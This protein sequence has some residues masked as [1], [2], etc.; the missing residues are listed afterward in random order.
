M[1]IYIRLS[2]VGGR[3]GEEYRSPAIQRGEIVRWMERNECTEGMVVVDEDVSGGKAV[4]S[5][6]LAKLL[7]RCEAGDSHGIVTYRLDRFGR[8]H[9][10]N[11]LA[12]KR[13]Q[14]A[15]TRL[16][17]VMDGVDS[18]QPQAK[19]MLNIMSM[20]A[21]DYLDRVKQNWD[22]ATTSAVAEGKHIAS[23]AP[24]G[25]LRADVADPRFDG[26]GK[27]IRDA[28]LVVDPV[29]GP[30]I[31]RA[32][33]MRASGESYEKIQDMLEPHRRVAKTTLAHVFQNRVYLGEARGPNGASNTEAHDPLTTEVVFNRCAPG[34]SPRRT[35][36]SKGALLRGLVTCDSCGHKLRVVG[37]TVKG[38]RVPSYVCHA[39]FASGACEAPS[40]GRVDR[41]DAYVL[42]Q[43]WDSWDERKEA[44][45]DY[46]SAYLQA[47]EDVRLAEEAL[48]ETVADTSLPPKVFKARALALQED[49]DAKQR[50]RWD[51]DE[52]DVDLTKPV[53]YIDGK[54]TTYEVW[55]EDPEAD[56]R[57][58]RNAIA[59]VT[60]AKADPA[61]R[62]FQPISERVH[63]TW[64]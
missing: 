38:V 44:I 61:R 41:V 46:A 24:I 58:L 25:Y 36:L 10:E 6:G 16:V 30:L 39:R 35:G 22:A 56:R 28:R 7:A 21:E 12:V 31:T 20:Q 29:L 4:A 37:T 45:T 8:D 5:R 53:A 47:R 40:A 60:L 57:T 51:M 11:I 23:K 26:K 14:D 62:R 18:D 27:L 3:E 64:R 42:E 49:L 63:I 54:P 33:E 15:G 55:G 2:R 9:T 17:T 32:F 48:Q 19:W 50:I 52:P 13:M 43:L 59:K 34:R 1:D